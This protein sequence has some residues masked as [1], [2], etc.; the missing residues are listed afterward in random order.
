MLGSNY[1]PVQEK[2]I[3]IIKESG[4]VTVC[5]MNTNSNWPSWFAG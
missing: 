4:P 1:G 5:S 3:E 2:V